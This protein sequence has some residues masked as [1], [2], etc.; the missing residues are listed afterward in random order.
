MKPTMNTL[1][2]EEEFLQYL[3][4]LGKG[5][6]DITPYMISTSGF[7]PDVFYTALARY[8]PAIAGEGIKISINIP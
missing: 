8:Y 1:P 3:L 2:M 5:R 4:S 6:H 7:S